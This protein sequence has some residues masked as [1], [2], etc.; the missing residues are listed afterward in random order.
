M[1]LFTL[2]QSTIIG[3]PPLDRNWSD[4]CGDPLTARASL[5]MERG[6]VTTLVDHCFAIGRKYYFVRPDDTDLG[7][8]PL[9]A[10]I[11]ARYIVSQGLWASEVVVAARG[12]HNVALAG[13]LT[14]ESGYRTGNYR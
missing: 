1:L 14:G 6:T 2:L 5:S 13:N 12:C 11:G 4:L 8:L 7:H 9:I 10:L 3:D